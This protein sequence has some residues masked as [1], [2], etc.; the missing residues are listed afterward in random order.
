[1][2]IEVIGKIK[3]KNNGTFALLDASDVE[4]ADGERLDSA[5]DR[6]NNKIVA[7]TKE[8]YENGTWEAPEGAIVVVLE[9][10]TE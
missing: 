2:A 6:L 9:G 3:Q 4:L 10:V 8:D 7:I 1:M 5:V